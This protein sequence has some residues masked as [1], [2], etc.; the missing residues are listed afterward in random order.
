MNKNRK[1]K[2]I[3]TGVIYESIIAA[4]KA[5]YISHAAIIGACRGYQ[6]TAAGFH[7]C[8]V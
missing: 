2:C 8:Y 4:A 7:W 5:V 3:E 1:V 6:K